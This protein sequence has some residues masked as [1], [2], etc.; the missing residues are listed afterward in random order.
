PPSGLQDLE[1]AAQL[2]DAEAFPGSCASQPRDVPTDEARGLG[3]LDSDAGPDLCA[4]ENNALLRKPLQASAWTD[5]QCRAQ[6]GPQS[7]GP[8]PFA[9]TGRRDES[10][11]AFIHGDVDLEAI[12][13]GHSTR[14]MHEQRMAHLAAFRMEGLLDQQRS[15]VPTA[16]ELRRTICALVAHLQPGL[17]RFSWR[18]A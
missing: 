5:R 4:I 7:G 1:A 16:C 8:I 17:P 13:A 9:G 3:Q 15:G 2:A 6:L 10:S 11:G 18:G 12:P 14:R